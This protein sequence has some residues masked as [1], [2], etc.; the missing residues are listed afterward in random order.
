ML[1]LPP[2]ITNQEA[3]DALAMLL[4]ALRREPDAEVAIDASS[5]QHFDSA[6]LSVLLECERQARAWG[7]GLVVRNTP[8]KLC[9]LARMYGVESLLRLEGQGALTA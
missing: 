7:K 6:A 9:A 1:L 3:L 8:P 4:P 2:T 5:L